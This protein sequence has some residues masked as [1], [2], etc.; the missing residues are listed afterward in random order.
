MSITHGT[1]NDLSD[2]LALNL[3][4]LKQHA[5]KSKEV[6]EEV[7]NRLQDMR[8]KLNTEKDERKILRSKLTCFKW[9][10]KAIETM[11][12]YLEGEVST[13]SHKKQRSLRDL[14]STLITIHNNLLRLQLSDFLE[15]AS[16]NGVSVGK[17]GMW[18][19]QHEVP[20]MWTGFV[21]TILSGGIALPFVVL[22][23]EECTGNRFS[24]ALYYMQTKD[25]HKWNCS[26]WV[27]QML[28]FPD[29]DAELPEPNCAVLSVKFF[30]RMKRRSYDSAALYIP[31]R[32][33]LYNELLDWRLARSYG[34]VHMESSND[35][36]VC[37]VDEIFD[38]FPVEIRSFQLM[39]TLED[40]EQQR[41]VNNPLDIDP[42]E[43]FN[44]CLGDDEEDISVNNL[45]SFLSSQTYNET[46]QLI[47]LLTE[48]IKLGKGLLSQSRKANVQKPTEV[49]VVERLDSR[50]DDAP[51][52]VSI[53]NDHPAP[54]SSRSHR[55]HD[56]GG[57]V[58]LKPEDRA[59]GR[60]R[61]REKMERDKREVK[62]NS[63]LRDDFNDD[64]LTL[65][66]QKE[67]ALLKIS[68]IDDNLSRIQRRNRQSSGASEHR[69]HE[70]HSRIFDSSRWINENNN[71]QDHL[72]KIPFPEHIRNNVQLLQK[73]TRLFLSDP[74]YSVSRPFIS[75]QTIE[76][77]LHHHDAKDNE[78]LPSLVLKNGDVIHVPFTEEE[79][80]ATNRIIQ[81]FSTDKKKIVM[82][83]SANLIGRSVMDCNRYYQGA[84]LKKIPGKTFQTDR[85]VVYNR[86]REK[87]KGNK[88]LTR[89]VGRFRSMGNF[90][91]SFAGEM[92]KISWS[93]LSR[94]N[95]LDTDFHPFR[96]Q[97]AVASTEG[98]IVYDLKTGKPDML[99]GHKD[100]VSFIRYSRDAEYI[101]TTGYDKTVRTWSADT[102]RPCTTFAAV[103]GEVGH[104]EPVILMDLHS[105]HKQLI[106]TADKRRDISQKYT[107]YFSDRRLIYNRTIFFWDIDRGA[108]K[109]K[110]RVNSDI[111]GIQFIRNY[112][113]TG[114]DNNSSK[115]PNKIHCW[116]IE[117]G[118]PIFM[119]N[120]Q[121]GGTTCLSVDLD[122]NSLMSATSDGTVHFYDVRTM[123][124]SRIFHNLQ[125]DVNTLSM[126]PC[127]LYLQSSSA[128][129]GYTVIFDA[130]Y[131]AKYLQVLR[132]PN[133]SPEG[134]LSTL[135]TKQ[136]HIITAGGDHMIRTWDVSRG[137]PLVKCLEG[138]TTAVNSLCMP[139]DETK[140]VSG[141][142]DCEL[143]LWGL[144][145]DRS[146]LLEEHTPR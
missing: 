131:S 7:E 104:A 125:S 94:G 80:D 19:Q 73:Y 146:T 37:E 20:I 35:A 14:S 84:L 117:T 25:S 92:K 111:M 130:R 32:W 6:I 102:F 96:T 66:Y 129:D 36:I 17:K 22:A 58:V 44:L 82:E 13:L 31:E 112:F 26:R 27:L 40:E 95:V 28:E 124:S 118:T 127:G 69:V 87:E 3:W 62:A 33:G 106:A 60:K 128:G 56:T 11:V 59:A 109:Q 5:S 123:K 137:D 71:L 50:N 140:L 15:F 90:R 42:D 138:H 70:H 141:G 93:K 91:G 135:W 89:F 12:E 38:P 121:K 110:L 144:E 57:L 101:I 122:E 103:D 113:F 119:T 43:T 99:E 51:M 67:D 23:M 77:I 81:K 18:L 68:V 1:H 61:E 107:G 133:S 88:N 139:R 97:L 48:S 41:P 74:S 45:D 78:P 108:A 64:S 2:I 63:L 24:T 54:S 55:D 134:V 47:Q 126:S 10:N 115:A 34:R 120:V 46:D 75:D 79:R 49:T 136:S 8:P 52:D 116:D 9:E 21:A 4:R 16:T 98:A 83:M 30:A 105:K 143:I 100:T 114:L 86:P 29:F 145:S 53:E 65:N 85:T 142:D 72:K 76:R 39:G 132:H